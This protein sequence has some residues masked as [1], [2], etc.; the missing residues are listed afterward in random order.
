MIILSRFSGYSMMENAR[1]VTII[2]TGS[3]F[4]GLCYAL[5]EKAFTK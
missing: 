5:W 2:L 3:I 1:D 4:G